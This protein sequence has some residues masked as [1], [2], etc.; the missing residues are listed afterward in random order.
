MTGFSAIRDYIDSL[1][2]PHGKVDAVT[3]GRHRA[4]IAARLIVPLVVLAG[5]PVYVALIGVPSALGLAFLVWLM[6]PLALAVFVSRTGRLEVAYIVSAV[7]FGGLAITLSLAAGSGA[8]LAVA[9]LALVPLEAALSRNTRVTIAT[10]LV[11][12]LSVGAILL[13]DRFGW[14]QRDVPMPDAVVFVAAAV[15]FFYAVG[16][17]TVILAQGRAVAELVET[18]VSQYELLASHMTDVITR[19]GAQG[20]VTFVSPAAERLIG[21]SVAALQGQGLFDR[22]HVADRPAYLNALAAAATHGEPAAVEFRLRTGAAERSARE[23]VFAWVEMR[24]HAISGNEGAADVVCVLRDISD[25]KSHETELARIHADTERASEAKTRFL[26][27][28]SHELRTPLNAIIGFSDMLHQ[29]KTLQLDQPRRLEYAR[30]INDSGQHLLSVVNGLLDMSKIETGKFELIIEPFCLRDVVE[31]C[32]SMLGL[33]A[34]QAGVTFRVNVP[35]DLPD[36]TADKRAITQ[37]LINL[38]SNAVKFSRS[39]GRVEINACVEMARLRIDIV[40]TGIGIAEEDVVRLGDPFFQARNTYDRPYEGTGL[41]L[42]VVKGLLD[43][44]GGQV[45]ISSR[46]GEGT[47]VVIRMPL[48]CEGAGRPTQEAPTIVTV[49][50]SRQRPAAIEAKP[51]FREDRKRA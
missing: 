47:H 11:C 17:A 28:M 18:Q 34:Q 12:A 49:P 4:F 25:R 23:T 13:A 51:A 31:N 14:L 24:A 2:H 29:E 7:T 10:G 16:L 45:T 19:H 21:A 8:Y 48:D 15:G 3:F 33:K 1:V 6:A 41:G 30:L 20:A 50:G 37:V 43:L 27:V 46:V 38:I 26:A 36:V 39:G 5:V 40:D 42:T 22:V 44:H 32:T 9:W 35:D